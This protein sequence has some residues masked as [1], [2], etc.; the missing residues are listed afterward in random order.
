MVCRT[1]PFLKG[2]VSA[3]FLTLVVSSTVS[4]QTQWTSEDAVS[5]A[6]S[7]HNAAKLEQARARVLSA[8]AGQ[9]TR[10]QPPRLNVNHMD[11][12]VETE[13]GLELSQNFDVVPWRGGYDGVVEARKSAL[14]HQ[15]VARR[16]QVAAQTRQAYFAVVYQQQRR[17]VLNTGHARLK[18]ALVVLRARH[19]KGALSTYDLRRFEREVST[20]AATLSVAES[21]LDAAWSRLRALAPFEGERPSLVTALSPESSPEP[22]GELPSVAALEKGAEA[23][24]LERELTVHTAFR[25]WT[26]TAGYRRR[27]VGPQRFDGWMVSLSLPLAFWDNNTSARAQLDAQEEVLRLQAAR[28][29]ERRKSQDSAVEKRFERLKAALA[30]LPEPSLHQETTRMAEAAYEGGEIP[31]HSLLDAYSSETDI[32]LSRTELQWRLRQTEIEWTALRGQGGNE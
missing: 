5:A 1:F 12:G 27:D 4:A 16:V 24:Q 9:K 14:A 21:D 13:S 25:N 19:D 23:N 6:F 10:W 7:L 8:N 20:K 32:H 2:G 22:A 18:D 30:A 11:V 17:E 31:L 15:T 29:N 3:V 28:L 26:A